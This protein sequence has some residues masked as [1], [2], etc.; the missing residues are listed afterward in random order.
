MV[1]PTPPSHAGLALEV[2]GVR[3]TRAE[4]TVLDVPLLEIPAQA[5]LALIGPPKS[6]KSLLLRTLAALNRPPRGGVWWG[7][8]NVAAMEPSIAARWRRSTLGMIRI[9][10]GIPLL[11]VLTAYQNVVLSTRL[12]GVRVTAAIRRQAHALLERAG[13]PDNHPTNRLPPV[14]LRRLDIVRALVHSPAVILADEP[15]EG[16]SAHDATDVVRSLCLLAAS[17]G[18]TTVM[19]TRDAA[20]SERFD[21]TYALVSGILGREQN[22]TPRLLL[23][24]PSELSARRASPP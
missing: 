9:G 17:V 2:R 10:V 14:D 11:P 3:L 12:R 4:R 8:I 7:V 21:T 20:L 22:W 1:K 6:G 18:A 16:L 23:A 5:Q 19:A 24:R 15:A 13:I